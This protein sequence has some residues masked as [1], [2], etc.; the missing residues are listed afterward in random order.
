MERGEA[1]AA[2]DLKAKAVAAVEE[3]DVLVLEQ[4]LRESDLDLNTIT[5]T[6]YRHRSLLMVA[7]EYKQ[8]H[9]VKWL[10]ENGNVTVEMEDMH[11]C[12]RG[13]ECN[14]WLVTWNQLS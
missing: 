6:D 8:L 12:A 13:R 10:W 9:V 4:L 14:H 7:C 1:D 5:A 11:E 3:G 2:S